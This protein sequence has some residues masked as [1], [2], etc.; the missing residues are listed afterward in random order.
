MT[1]LTAE[2]MFSP[3]VALHPAPFFPPTPEAA[4][5]LLEF[6]T[7]AVHHGQARCHS[8][9]SSESDFTAPD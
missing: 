5:R 7:A 8:M 4:R 6:F 3:A 2:I 9:E 1:A